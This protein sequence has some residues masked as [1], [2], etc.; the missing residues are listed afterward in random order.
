MFDVLSALRLHAENKPDDAAIRNGSQLI[1]YRQ[2]DRMTNAVAS[3][4][5]ELPGVV[6][7][8]AP[9]SVEWIVGWLGLARAGKTVV[10]LPPFFSEQQLAH[11]LKDSQASHI[12]TIESMGD[13]LD[14]L[15]QPCSPI[16]TLIRDGDEAASID[17]EQALQSRHIVYTSGTTGAPKGVRLGASQI[18]WSAAALNK[19]VNAGPD[20]HY[21][22]VLPFALLLEQICGI[23]APLLLGAPVTIAP[24]VAASLMSGNPQSLALA[25]EQA[26]PSITV[27]VPEFLSA[28]VAVLQA[29]GATAPDT[30]RAVAVGGAPIAPV[31]AENA[32]SLGIP[33]CEGYGLSEC[34]SVVSVNRPGEGAPGTVGKPL[35][36]L[37]VEI[38]DGEIVV[39]GPSVME[40]YLHHADVEESWATG[41]LG[42]IDGQGNLVV[43][44]RRDNVIVLANGRN[45]SPEWIE[46]MM[47][48]DPKIASCVLQGHGESHIRASVVPSSSGAQWFAEA[49]EKDITQLIA[50]L[51]REAPDYARPG[52]FEIVNE[53]TLAS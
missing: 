19:A 38:V 42:M 53:T 3:S 6:A 5:S 1:T 32:R 26:Q 28:W 39:A 23:C 45:V 10:T 20:D 35:E 25:I 4:L 14:A 50:D 36:G 34:C 51:C 46:A 22:S 21:L 37:K 2:L 16:E 41:D 17:A 40:G 52:S 49:L 30:L 47:L 18:D 8:L 24:D 27:L 44:G 11:I 15:A 31:L 9:N 12:L 43:L 29:Q 33:V 7:I 13:R 48:A